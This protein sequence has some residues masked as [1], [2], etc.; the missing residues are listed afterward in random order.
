MSFGEPRGWYT[1]VDDG[2]SV[3]TPIH[4]RIDPPFLGP[5][6]PD[7]SLPPPPPAS[8][9]PLTPV[10][11]TIPDPIAVVPVLCMWRSIYGPILPIGGCWIAILLS[12]LILLV[13]LWYL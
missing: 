2:L 5:S 11:T 3:R 9:P 7:I 10:P 1:N 12:V 4:A 8:P 13:L 6:L